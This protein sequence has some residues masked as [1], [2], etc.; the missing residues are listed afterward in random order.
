MEN[1]KSLVRLRDRPALVIAAVLLVV[2]CGAAL[3]VRIETAVECMPYLRGID[4]PFISVPALNILQT[5]DLNPHFFN[6]PSLPIY[7]TSAAFAVG[8]LY[9]AA[10]GELANTEEIGSVNYPYYTHTEI[11]F[12]P[13]LLFMVFSVL[14]L[15]FAGIAGYVAFREPAVLFLAPLIAVFS[16]HYFNLSQS[17]LNVDIVGTFFALLALMYLAINMGNDGYARKSVWP[18]VLSGLTVAS[19][20]TLVFIFLPAWLAVWLR[21]KKNRLRKTLYIPLVALG[22]FIL[23]V[24]YSVLDLRAFLDHVGYEAHHYAT[25]HPGFEGTP[26]FP[27]FLYYAN[28][29]L[30]DYGYWSLIF[31]V[32]GIVFAFW[33]NWRLALILTSFPAAHLYYMSG[34]TVRFIRNIAPLFPLYALFCAL[35]LVLAYRIADCILSKAPGTTSWGI[36]RPGVAVAAMTVAF[37]AVF[38][39]DR[40][41]AWV[42]SKPESRHLAERWLREHA[43]P[44]AAII[45]P[46]ELGMDSRKLAQDYRVSTPGLLDGRVEGLHAMLVRLAE[47]YV[48]LPEYAYEPLDPEEVDRGNFAKTAERLNKL[49]DGFEPLVEFPGQPVL[50]DH[51]PPVPHGNPRIYVLRYVR[52]PPPA[53]P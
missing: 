9:A 2:V 10:Q 13:R 4:G 32:P 36:L 48:L 49:R 19:K 25:G 20:Y 33:R 46:I 16:R 21:G 15:A 44:G 12:P 37:V 34:Q 7:L 23:V 8:Y 26:G 14:A 11:Q 47:A 40:P 29:L 50:L 45:I 42:L 22:T 30:S 3:F 5:S 18:G 39:T 24:P 27:Q 43:G 31:F 41:A 28:A 53:S 17:Y 52:T 6:Y 35:G 38:P 51:S 1:E